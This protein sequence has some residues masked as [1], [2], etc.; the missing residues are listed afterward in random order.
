[1]C[2]VIVRYVQHP[3]DVDSNF[4]SYLAPLSTVEFC[5]KCN[6][7]IRLWYAIFSKVGRLAAEPVTVELLK[8]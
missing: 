7:F 1:M 2:E 5:L 8:S 6:N 4:L 3:F